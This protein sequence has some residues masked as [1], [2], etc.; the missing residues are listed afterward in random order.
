MPRRSWWRQ[1]VRVLL[2]MLA[3]VGTAGLIAVVVWGVWRVPQALYAYVPEPK[4]RASVE[5][6]TRTGLIAGLAGLVL[7]AIQDD[8]DGATHHDDETRTTRAVVVVTVAA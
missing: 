2:W 4:D 6:T 5:A 8:D 1:A 7:P 3:G